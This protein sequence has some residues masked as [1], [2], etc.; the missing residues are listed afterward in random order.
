MLTKSSNMHTRMHPVTH[1]L[2]KHDEHTRMHALAGSGHMNMSTC[3]SLPCCPASSLAL[4]S[5]WPAAAEHDKSRPIHTHVRV[6]TRTC[7]C[8]C[9][10]L[11]VHV[12][13]TGAMHD[14]SWDQSVCTHDP[15]IGWIRHLLVQLL[16]PRSVA[17]AAFSFPRFFDSCSL[18]GLLW[19]ESAMCAAKQTIVW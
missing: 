1:R 14:E 6:C 8:V 4:C 9:V 10:Y 18:Y 17:V 5:R 12:R 13:T 3:Q 15:R 7:H 11:C 16:Q 19:R 2:R